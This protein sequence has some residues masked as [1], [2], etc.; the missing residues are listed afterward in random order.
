LK[1]HKELYVTTI[2]ALDTFY[3]GELWP[4]NNGVHINAHGG[5]ILL[6]EGTYYWFGE[7]KIEGTAGN[8]AHVGVHCYSSTDLY[9]WKDEGIALAV[10]DDPASDIVK[11]NVIER[12]K[13]I[14]CAAT[15]KFVMWFHLELAGQSYKAART[16]T[17]IS[18]TPTGPYKFL[19]SFRPN[20]G[21]WPINVPD[22]LKKPLTPEE[23]AT[24]AALNLHG[25]PTP[26]YPT[27]QI[28]RRD[29]A[30]GQMS[31]DMTLF[32]DDD[33]AAYHIHASEDNGVL[34]IS[35]LTAD[36][37]RPSGKYAR[38]FPGQ[39]NEA[40]ALFKRN[41][42]YYLLS[43]GCTGWDPNAAR[44]AVADSIW[45][46]WTELGNPCIGPNAELT[47]DGQ[48]THVLPVPG[49]PDAYIF[50]ADRWQPKNAIDG[51]YLWLPIDFTAD[52]PHIEWFN[53]WDLSYFTDR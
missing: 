15:G 27:D 24:L 51:R 37:L 3:P 33:G 4:D 5:G 16:A 53:S 35:Q 39:F 45:G 30:G 20:A 47:F 31:R 46:P 43:S 7:H 38:F 36:Y 18:D 12:P 10:S 17:A 52:T 40:P 48:A 9:N 49:I 28:F 44:S 22:E 13:V 42:K 8:A 14:H 2:A 23:S 32:V 34:H 41:G 1:F 11:G 50:L 6:H 26:G 21:H 25:G 29:F 19:E